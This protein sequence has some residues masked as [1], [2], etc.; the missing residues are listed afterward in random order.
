MPIAQGKSRS[1]RSASSR[2][3]GETCA[4]NGSG[5]A[6]RAQ[7]SGRDASSRRARSRE[8]SS[9][10]SAPTRQPARMTGTSNGRPAPCSPAGTMRSLRIR[11]SSSNSRSTC[12]RP[13]QVAL[14]AERLRRGWP[15]RIPPWSVD[16][17]FAERWG[18]AAG[19]RGQARVTPRRRAP[20]RLSGPPNPRVDAPP[21]VR[22]R[23]LRSPRKLHSRSLHLPVARLARR[24]HPAVLRS[25]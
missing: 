1:T 16:V 2:N 12:L 3:C 17:R 24:C 19:Q 5:S 14:P 7:I 6:M 22:A 15:S 9:S 10:G 20:C 21:A 18:R 4:A 25:R 11:P 13:G 8:R 23:A